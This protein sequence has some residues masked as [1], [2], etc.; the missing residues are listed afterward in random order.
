MRR[1][2]VGDL[3]GSYNLLIDK[4][5]EINF[6]KT[7]DIMYSVGDLI[8]R[9]PDSLKC[10]KLIEEPW[11]KSVMGNHEELM[12]DV[13]LNGRNNN[14]WIMN[15]GMWYLSE[16]INEVKRLARLAEQ[17]PYSRT[18]DNIGICHAESPT[19]DWND[20]INPNELNKSKMVWGR[21]K[22]TQKSIT[23]NIKQ[24]YHGHTIKPIVTVS[25]NATFIDTGAYY[26]GNLTVLE[27]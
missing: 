22:I 16:D 24:T 13:I 5:E 15:G 11:F 25:G 3:H 10:L 17:L 6:N 21:S 4:L 9:G 23:K 19:S 26:T 7:K 12:I 14:L 20:A 8:D 1:F 18:I 2:I 27:I